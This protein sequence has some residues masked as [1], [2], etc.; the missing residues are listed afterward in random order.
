MENEGGDQNRGYSLVRVR[1][2]VSTKPTILDVSKL[3]NTK[4]EPDV[5]ENT[6]EERSV[7][8]CCTEFFYQFSR[9]MHLILGVATSV[10]CY[11]FYIFVNSF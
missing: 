3:N 6:K 2:I 1:R 8:K 10:L 9:N 4:I 7:F 11:Y 5:D